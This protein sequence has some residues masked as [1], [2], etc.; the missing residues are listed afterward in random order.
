MLSCQR[1]FCEES[2]AGLLFRIRRCK[3][4]IFFFSSNLDISKSLFGFSSWCGS[5]SASFTA[6]LISWLHACVM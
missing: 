1:F 6:S 5:K 3:M 2:M 4:K